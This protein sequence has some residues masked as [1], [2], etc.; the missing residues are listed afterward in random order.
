MSLAVNV[1]IATVRELEVGATANAV[2]TGFVVSDPDGSV[3]EVVAL[4]PAETL[5]AAS[6]AHAYRVWEPAEAN[7]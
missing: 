4:L 1:V 6:R 7:V 5:P 2:T 3:M